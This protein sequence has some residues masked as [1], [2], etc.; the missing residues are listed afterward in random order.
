MRL[1]RSFYAQPTQQLAQALLGCRLV[2]RW[3]GQRLSGLIVETEAYCGE[4]DLACHARAGRTG[5]TAVMYGRPGLAYVYFTYGRHWLLNVVSE[6]EDFPAAVLIRALEPQEG[7]DLMRQHRPVSNPIDLCRGPAKLTQALRI[8]QALNGVDLCNRR[9]ELWIE[10]GVPAPAR[11]VKRGPRVGL[12]ATP[13]PWLSKPW[14]YWLQD[15]PFV[16]R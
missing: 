2:R 11:S 5:R 6:V 13:E 3:H 12:G 4:T 7:L 8:D 15:N 16:S 10:P 9:G 14:R 1:T